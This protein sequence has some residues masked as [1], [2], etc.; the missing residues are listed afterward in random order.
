MIGITSYIREILFLSFIQKK[1]TGIECQEDRKIYELFKTIILPPL[2]K[3]KPLEYFTSIEK[4]IKETP[5][6]DLL[7]YFDLKYDPFKIL[8]IAKNRGFQG[9]DIK[10]LQNALYAASYYGHLQV[11]K[12][13]IQD[14]HLDPSVDNNSAV[15]V[16]SNFGH[17]EIVRF[18]MQDKRMDLSKGFGLLSVL[19]A[20]E[21]GHPEIVKFLL[22]HES[23]KPIVSDKL[24]SM[25]IREAFDNN[26]LTIVD[27][28]VEYRPVKPFAYKGKRKCVDPRAP[29]KRI[30]ISKKNRKN[31]YYKDEF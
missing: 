5:I 11:V 29:E 15:I 12:I 20:S 28:L 23:V 26:H 3:L 6:D 10:E 22:Q 31:S 25:A 13:L 21:K 17:L 7:Q 16:A 4:E 1:I 18:L 9:I 8:V 19:L 27:F 2:S 24:V 14:A 30:K